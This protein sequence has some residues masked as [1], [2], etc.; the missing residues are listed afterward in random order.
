MF[1]DG[2]FDLGHFV[3]EAFGLSWVVISLP[4]IPTSVFA[5]VPMAFGVFRPPAGIAGQETA[6]PLESVDDLT[7]GRTVFGFQ[8]FDHFLNRA[9]FPSQSM[10]SASQSI[11]S[12]S[13][14]IRSASQSM[15]SASQS[16]RS[17]CTL[18]R[19]T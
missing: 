6:N 16:I 13:Q 5:G 15:R 9:K 17:G 19:S 12:A 3:A 14:S 2:R 10:R 7:L 18:P 4:S 11:R 8:A 1:G